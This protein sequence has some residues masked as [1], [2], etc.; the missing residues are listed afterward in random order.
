MK[1]SELMKMA[2]DRVLT[3]G[4]IVRDREGTEF[5]F[6]GKT[7]QILDKENSKP[8]KYYGLCVDDDWT[9]TEYVETAE[10]SCEGQCEHKGI[11]TGEVKATEESI[12]KLKQFM[13]DK[14]EE[15]KMYFEATCGDP[16]NDG[17]YKCVK[18]VELILVEPNDDILAFWE[19][20]DRQ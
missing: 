2:E 11:Y 8:N 6:T 18:D 5:I 9:I 7:F 3:I 4:R 13:Q 1:S 20:L 15:A 14:K 10:D 12:E 16:G 17:Y 19:I